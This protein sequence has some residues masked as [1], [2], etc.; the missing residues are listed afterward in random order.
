[1]KIRTGYALLIHL[2]LG[3]AAP[4]IGAPVH[5]QV[6][7]RTADA[8]QPSKTPAS[9]DL[10]VARG[11]VTGLV[12][13]AALAETRLEQSSSKGG[14]GMS[15][16]LNVFQKFVRFDVRGMSMAFQAIQLKVSFDVEEGDE[17]TTHDCLIPFPK[18]WAA[19]VADSI[20]MEDTTG[21]EVTTVTG[22]NSV[23]STKFK[24]YDANIVAVRVEVLDSTGATLYL[25][26]WPEAPLESVTLPERLKPR[27]F[28]A[29]DGRKVEAVVGQVKD[30][31]VILVIKGTEFTLPLDSLSEPD[32][33][34]LR[35]MSGTSGGAAASATV[36]TPAPTSASAVD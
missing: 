8:P 27:T 4:F 17:I 24:H 30:G 29:K 6:Y 26:S 16:R 7:E 10:K 18:D 35:E 15:G 28:T 3:P 14:A 1:M 21:S 34:Y 20:S 23:S 9:I 31:N 11:S 12:L 5:G 2:A 36:P 19:F 22:F 32:Q 13:R 25:A 33:E